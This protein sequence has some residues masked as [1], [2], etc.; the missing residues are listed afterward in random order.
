MTWFVA[1]LTM[2]EWRRAANRRDVACC[3]TVPKDACCACCAP[4]AD[5]R[6]KMGRWMGDILG[7]ALTDKKVKA[8]VLVAFAAVAAGGFAGCALMQIDADVNDFIPGGSYLK[9]WIADS[10]S[11]Y[12]TL[13]DSIDVYTRDMDVHTETGAAAVLAASAAFRANPHR[14]RVGGFV[15][16]G[17]QRVSRRDR[18]VRLRRLF[19]FAARRAARRSTTTSCGSTRRAPRLS[20]GIQV[21]RMR[22]NHIKA[23]S[24]NEKV[25]SMDSLRASLASVAGN[26]EGNIF[27]F[28][29]AWLN[30]EQYKAIEVEAIRNISSTMAVM[31]VII[32][33]LLV[34]PKA[35]AVVCFSPVPDHRQHHRLH[36]LLGPVPGLGHHH[37]AH[38]R[39]RLVRGLRRAHRPRV[40]GGPRHARREAPYVPREHGRR[41]VQRRRLHVPRRAAPERLEEL[42]VHHVFASSS[43]ASLGLAHGLVLLPVLMSIVNPKPYAAGAFGH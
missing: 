2:D 42:R 13:G 40:H 11:M 43:C 14:R 36:A 22:G 17:V 20:E 5:G 38:H 16:R 35:V 7:G 25:K 26:E 29:S 32:A 6:T 24:S 3:L 8:G 39:A 4:R 23:D 27:A 28:S 9:E 18:R 1:W 33:F 31:V 41:R 30:Y 34:N 37:H 15:D 10:N 12:R 19:S 21:T